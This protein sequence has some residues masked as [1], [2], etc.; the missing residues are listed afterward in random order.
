MRCASPDCVVGTQK[1]DTE[2]KLNGVAEVR[3]SKSEDV[4][5]KDDSYS[6]ISDLNCGRIST[7][8][9]RPRLSVVRLLKK[10]TEARHRS[11]LDR[12]FYSCKVCLQLTCLI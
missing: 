1:K 5:I 4:R 3:T 8:P 6:V 2:F 7:L 11:E 12:N 9:T 10:Y